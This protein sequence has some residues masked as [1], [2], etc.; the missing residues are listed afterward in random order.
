MCFTVVDWLLELLLGVVHGEH[1]PVLDPNGLGL[2]GTGGTGH[3]VSG[4]SVR[5][6]LEKKR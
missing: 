3:M 1:V 5:Y 4:V 2:G 6:H